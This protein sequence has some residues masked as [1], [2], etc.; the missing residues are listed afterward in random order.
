MAEP[1]EV[2]TDVARH[3]TVFARNLW[4]RHRDR[5]GVTATTGLADVAPRIDLLI[6]GLF[7]RSYPIRV[8]EPPAPPTLLGAVFGGR[9]GPVRRRPV[10]ATDGFSL[11]LPADLGIT[12]SRLALERYR[13]MAL[14][15]AMRA[16]RGGAAV[17]AGE[18][19][20]LV[21]DFFLLL[22]ACAADA[23]L[24]RWLPGMAAPI[25]A[26]RRAALAARPPL[27]AFPKDAQPLERFVRRLVR[28]D[29]ARPDPAFTS[30]S[31]AESLEKAQRIAADLAPYGLRARRSPALFRDLWTGEFRAPPDPADA[32]SV[33][34]GGRSDDP[35]E[36]RPRA[37]RIE[38]RP[39]VRKPKEHED[40]DRGR[41]GAWMIQADEPHQKAEDPMGLQRPTDRDDP[42]R[43]D[44]MG[45]MLS[46]LGQARM[47]ATPGRPKEVLLSDDPPGSRTRLAAREPEADDAAA[48]SYPEWDYRAEAY[49]E[50]GATVRTTVAHP[51]PQ[52]WV[53]ETLE[54]HRGMLALIRR[55]FEM[56][57][58]RRV[59]LRRQAEGDE[60]DLDACIEALAD[61][62]AG[63]RMPDALYQTCRPAERNLAILLLIDVS[64]STDGWVSAHRRIIDVEREALLLVCI[65]LEELGEPYAVQ[66]FSGE[67]PR[68]VTVREIKRFDAAFD[69]DAALRIAALEP[70][71][72]TRAG[73]ALRHAAAA[74]MQRP[75]DHRLLLLLSDG[76]PND[77]DR[78]EG[79]YGVEDM[80]RAVSEAK[81]SGIFPFCLTIDRQAA[82]YLPR[83]FGPNQYALLPRPELL[84]TVLLEWMR[85]LLRPA[86]G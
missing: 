13:A 24:R 59:T 72:Y 51:G 63:A 19:S 25:E 15:Q 43:A 61:L 14:E 52:A 50:P 31:A 1:E 41:S 17:I 40:R 4:R 71:R 38:R 84:P 75:A 74:L 23:A 34:P 77:V 56:L 83:V 78:Y 29:G 70:K 26:A 53:D 54:R 8:A 69:N 60:I 11:W 82:G 28:A 65:A 46:E 42:E 58:A 5:G 76:K 57:R 27:Y 6:T 81:L 20:T 55:R 33:D 35:D 37:A 3:A 32:S 80:Q 64:G 66:A 49:R 21:Q 67:G 86:T 48:V 7:G 68:A 73:A 39:E 30:A 12:D 18:T 47:V 44:E 2:L 79:R 85:R 16:A 62:K 45:E 10:P 22:E 36:P 9:R